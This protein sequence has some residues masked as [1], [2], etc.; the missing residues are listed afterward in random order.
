[1]SVIARMNNPKTS[2]EYKV[3]QN[4]IR[5]MNENKDLLTL[6]VSVEALLDLM[7][8]LNLPNNF[9]YKT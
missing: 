7:A 6:L 4:V 1:M 2:I 9:A 5:V 3:F 8:I